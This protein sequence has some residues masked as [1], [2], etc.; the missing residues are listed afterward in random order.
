VPSDESGE[1][2]KVK[3]GEWWADDMLVFRERDAQESA[4]PLDIFKS[5]HCQLNEEKKS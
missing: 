5:V 1:H 3:K 4:L 2:P